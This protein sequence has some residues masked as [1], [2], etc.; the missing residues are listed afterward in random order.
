M[1]ALFTTRVS[2]LI[3]APASRIWQALT[4]PNQIQQ[5]LFGARTVTD[6]KVGSLIKWEGE[7]QGKP[8][9]DKGTVLKFVPEKLIETTYW[10][11]M[12]GM[13][14]SPANYK[15]VTYELTQ[16]SSDTL[17]T[18]TQDNNASEEERD[19]SEQN[20]KMVLDGLKKLVE[21]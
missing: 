7:W 17:L 12:A 8:Y 3:H 5:Y 20:W 21:R 9:E 2:I 19:H 4:D 1:S 16:K 6:W 18:L 14:D 15:R 10:S 13:P 11:S